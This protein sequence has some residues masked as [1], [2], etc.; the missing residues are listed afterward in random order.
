[1]LGQ[2][3][4]SREKAMG[5]IKVNRER[6]FL[7]ASPSSSPPRAGFR[8][9]SMGKSVIRQYVLWLKNAGFRDKGI[10]LKI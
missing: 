4:S 9:I 3:L 8:G 10:A 6:D 1:M 5:A 7:S 2:I